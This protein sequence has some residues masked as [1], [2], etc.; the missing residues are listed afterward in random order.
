MAR[1]VSAMRPAGSSRTMPT[2]AD[3]TRRGSDLALDQRLLGAPLGDVAEVDDDGGHLGIGQALT[4]TASR[5]RNS[6]SRC[7]QR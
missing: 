7:R 4:P 6:P 2:S 3:R 1:L 5:W